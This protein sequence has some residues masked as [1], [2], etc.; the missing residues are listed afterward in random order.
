M[1]IPQ[2][3]VDLE[4]RRR[5]AM[6]LR[7]KFLRVLDDIMKGRPPKLEIPK[8]TLANTIFDRER[9]IL[10]LGEEKLEREF[11]DMGE[12]RRFM[13]TLLMAAI[14]YQALVENEYPT[15]RDL[16]YRGKHTIIYRDLKGRLRQENTWDEQA[17]SDAV[18]RDIE[19]FTGLLRE[20]MLILSKEKGKV[21]GNLKI[22][23]GGD[24]IDLSKMGH[25]AYAI[26][27]TPDLI[28]F[29]DWDAEF[30]LVVE[31]DAV[32]QQLHRIGFWRKYKAILVTGAG[33]PDRATRRFV[34]RLNEELKLPIYILTD[35]IPADEVV[36]IRDAIT[37]KVAIGPIE[38]LI[39]HF[40]SGEDK[41]RVYIDLEVPAWDPLTGKIEWRRI[42][43][44]YRHRIRDKL[45]RIRTKGRGA[46]RVTKAHSLFV[47]RDGRIKVI[48]AKEIKPGDYIV[49]ASKLPPLARSE[50]LPVIDVVALLKDHA[51]K[52][53]YSARFDMN[54]TVAVEVEGELVRLGNISESAG[55]AR[56]V[57]LSRSSNV[58][59]ARVTV[60]EELAWVLGLYTS[61]G[62]SY[63][64]RY[65]VFNLGPDEYEKAERIARIIEEK[66]NV[67]PKITSRG[68]SRE[69]KQIC[70]EVRSRILYIVFKEL[71]LLGKS[72]TKR[73]PEIILNAPPRIMLSYIKGLIDGDG[74]I[75]GYGDIVYAT[76]SGILAKQV[77]NMLLS[78][79]VMPSYTANGEDHIIR[80]GKSPSRT[81]SEIYEYLTGGN[82]PG[83]TT[84]EPTYGAPINRELK[85]ILV[86]LMNEGKISYSPRGKTISKTKL[87][88]VYD[89]VGWLPGDYELIAL[90]DVVLAKVTAVEEE[91]YEGYVYDFMV[92]EGNS[93]VGSYG[94]VYHNSDPYGF[95][96]YSVYK[97]GSIQLSYESERLATPKARFLGVSMTD[98]F[99]WRDKK[100]FLTERERRNFIIKATD[101][102]IKRAK[103]L[104]KYS[105]FR[106]KGWRREL[107]IFLEKKAKLEIEA[108]ASKG[109]KFLAF[110]YIPKKIE[111]G[112]W[113]E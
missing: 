102:D 98:I 111:T 84:S 107:K 112:D 4:A 29:I 3:K 15:I 79:G 62:S 109:L 89:L 18:I 105:W 38:E 92:P 12:A 85:R 110:E 75:D 78:L 41:E 19:V 54:R 58:I 66:F 82:R 81:P 76:R 53:E 8:R 93:F 25:G 95:Y 6:I 73:V 83:V 36:V 87:A 71:G 90:G 42:G 97:V 34:R 48:P 101:A 106:S 63:G 35:S 24:M 100:P 11:L 43:Y 96:I 80:I 108:L 52:G 61:E 30:V 74:H 60:D 77:F 2:D 32:F 45:L 17:E 27:S 56:V 21:V 57:L 5:A 72:R 68:K 104:M 16:Y 39:G 51:S 10:V 94:V 37:G 55:K 67:R 113:I 88:K 64:R 47:F 69:Q 49:V 26:E 31:K 44:A 9:G 13:Q 7:E 99:G 20:D 46:I 23:S 22:R 28:E 70:V 91:D 40:F 50:E 59:P 103:E 86:K 65:L 1:S 14:I 33:Q